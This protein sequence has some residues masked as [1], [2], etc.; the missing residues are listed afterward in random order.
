MLS[1]S[2]A[3]AFFLGGTGITAAAFVLLTVDTMS[4]LNKR[5]N[6]E[7]LTPAVAH[8]FEIWTQNNCMGCHTLMGEGAYYAP[9][10]T[11]VV[12]RRGAP[13]IRAFLKDPE[14]MYPGR[15]KMVKYDIFDPKA[16]PNAEKNID[17]M[18]AFFSW[19]EK[20]D[21]NGFP[22]EPDLAGPNLPQADAKDPWAGAPEIVAVCKGCH[23]LK[24][25][26]GAVGPALDGVSKRLNPKDMAE[27]IQNPAKV[28]PGTAMPVLGLSDETVSALVTFLG[29]QE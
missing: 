24:G 17:D 12:S 26:G 1:K 20:I 14:A 2:A 9:E 18:I 5:S 29:K 8:G 6:Q 28:K 19:V 23:S 16:D 25:Q 10:L 13:W 3:R 15:R 7:A 21:L 22:P 27:W 4:Q 11:Q